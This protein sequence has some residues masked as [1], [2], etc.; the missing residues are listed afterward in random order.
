MRTQD[1]PSWV[2]RDTPVRV[3]WSDGRAD[4]LARIESV[5]LT[6]VRVRV[7]LKAPGRFFP[8]FF[9]LE[10]DRLVEHRQRASQRNDRSA[11][12]VPV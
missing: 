4:L 6:A 9:L 8:N 10:G 3:S 2:E 5:T 11:T 12:A 7:Q 1:I